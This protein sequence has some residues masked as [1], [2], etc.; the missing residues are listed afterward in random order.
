MVNIILTSMASYI[1][2]LNMSDMPRYIHKGEIIG[3]IIFVEDMFDNPTTENEK[4]KYWNHMLFVKA[5]IE[6]RLKI[7]K[8]TTQPQPA[9]R[10]DD[11]GLNSPKT[12]EMLNLKSY[13]FADLKELLDVGNLP[14]KLSKKA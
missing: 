5:I 7:E 4:T 8:A 13:L 2:V 10:T 3:S 11:D 6:A 12:A 1:L 9:S 14:P